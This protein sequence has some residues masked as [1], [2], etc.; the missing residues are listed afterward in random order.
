MFRQVVN[1]L[2]K[3][4][5]VDIISRYASLSKQNI[6]GDFRFVVM[7]KFL[8]S[9]NELPVLEKLIMNAYFF[10]KQF[11]LSEEK[12]FGLDTSNVTVEKVPF[13]ITPVRE[14]TLKRVN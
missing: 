1:E 9:E 10:L 14:F 12:A 4:K 5:E 8:S 11:S 3:N 2:V 7:K 6:I 13:I